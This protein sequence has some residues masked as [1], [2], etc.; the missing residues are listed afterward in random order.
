VTT[1]PKV[2]VHIIAYNQKNYIREAV[3][4]A[5]AQ[6]YPHLQV[7]VADDASTDGT[8]EIV[9]S[10]ADEHPGLVVPVLNKKNL[11]ITRNSNAALRACNGEFVAFM[12][13]DDVLLPGKIS[14]QVQW[15]LQSERR[16]LCGHQVEVFYQ[17]G[18]RS[19]H[20]LSRKMM[21]GIGADTFIR[22]CPFGATSVMVRAD[23]IPPHGFDETLPVV[24][25]QMLWVEVLRQDGEF[26]FIP[27]TYARYRQ[28]GGNVTRDPFANLSDVERHFA[29]I[30][31]RYPHFRKT[32][33]RAQTRWLHYNVGIALAAA[34][35]RREARSKYWHA[36]RREPCF[37]KA[38]I[39]L[40][41]TLI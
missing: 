31:E 1:T 18:S 5:L 4:S 20:P 9:Q 16:A 23:R 36:I 26:G 19:P 22:Y 24:S 8:A 41:Q 15:F 10:Y 25:D 27:G 32:V 6:D 28:H 29:N 17:D 39:R 13:G 38:W 30:A 7:V 33:H 3:D 2:S 21:S 12:G 40:A 35:H 14:A 11:G 37:I 34:G